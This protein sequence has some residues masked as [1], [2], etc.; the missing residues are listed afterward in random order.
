MEK[1]IKCA[2]GILNLV[3]DSI[4]VPPSKEELEEIFKELQRQHRQVNP[5][6]NMYWNPR[7][8]KALNEAL[9]EYSE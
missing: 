3:G 4:Y 7:L 5:L 1:E 2:E 8:E 6:E 9:E